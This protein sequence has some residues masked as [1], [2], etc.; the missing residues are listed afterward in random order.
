MALA[1]PIPAKTDPG[2]DTPTPCEQVQ[3][4]EVSGVEEPQE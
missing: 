3:D 2:I 1:L 4:R